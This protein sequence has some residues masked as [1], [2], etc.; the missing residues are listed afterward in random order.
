VGRGGEE[1][2][3]QMQTTGSVKDDAQT[4]HPVVKQGSRTFS[5][6]APPDQSVRGPI[7]PGRK[8]PLSES[9]SG[10]EHLV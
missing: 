8:S 5:S 1:R 9:L 10:R 2:T 6:T 4:R 3:D 7:D